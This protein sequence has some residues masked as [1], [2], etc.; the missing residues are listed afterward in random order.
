MQKKPKPEKPKESDWKAFKRVVPEIR[1]RYLEKVN[2]ELITIL[3]KNVPSPTERFWDAEER[4]R[5]EKKIM[6]ACF[7][8]HSRS[9]MIMSMM[10]MYRYDLLTDHDLHHFSEELRDRIA[11]LKE[12]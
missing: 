11:R 4:V 1:D 9:K 10:L 7:R 5:E 3:G 12:L 6:G 2:C 8:D